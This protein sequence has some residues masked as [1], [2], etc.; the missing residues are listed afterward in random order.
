VHDPSVC[1]GF[2]F[3]AWVDTLEERFLCS[4]Q[5]ISLDEL[6]L[7]L[8][9]IYSLLMVTHPEY[10]LGACIIVTSNLL[11]ATTVELW[12]FAAFLTMYCKNVI[13]S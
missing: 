1:A 10:T 4:P 11:R 5:L 6:C 13:V 12:N 2:L 9:I 8:Y 7:A 3:I